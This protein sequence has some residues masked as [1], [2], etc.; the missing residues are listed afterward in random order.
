MEAA[1]ERLSQAIQLPDIDGIEVRESGE[2]F[3][4]ALVGAA[5]GLAAGAMLALSYTS[6]PDVTAEP[7]GRW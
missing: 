5:L 3:G 7:Y 6:D 1:V 2:S 4:Y